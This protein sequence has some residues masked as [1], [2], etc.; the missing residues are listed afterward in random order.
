MDEILTISEIAIRL[1]LAERTVYAMAA[2]GELPAF[3]LRGQWRMRQ[4]DF[5]RRQGDH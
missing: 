5:G 1:K 4:S 2:G 3:K